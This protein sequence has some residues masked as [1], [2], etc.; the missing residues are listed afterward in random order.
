MKY[1]V[2]NSVNTDAHIG[3]CPGCGHGIIARLLAEGKSS[4]GCLPA[5]CFLLLRSGS[6]LLCEHSLDLRLWLDADG[7]VDFL[8]ITENDQRGDAHDAELHG[9]VTIFIGVAFA[10]NGFAFILV[11]H[12]LHN[13]GNVA[14]RATPSCPK[15]DNYQRVTL[16]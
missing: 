7:F 16:Y 12:L 13:G 3:W 5:F 11:S 2:P 6:F 8:A 4:F 9:D 14:A 15:I 10:D 1:S